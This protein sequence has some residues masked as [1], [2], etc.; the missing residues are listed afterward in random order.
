[1]EHFQEYQTLWNGENGKV[2][3]Y[4]SEIPYDGPST[5]AWSHNG[6]NGWAAYKVA[7][8]VKKHEAIGLGIYSFF[9]DAPVVMDN[10]AEA[11]KGTG[12]KFTNIMTFW[13]TGNEASAMNS[14][15]QEQVPDDGL[16]FD[17][18]SVT[19]MR[20]ADNADYQGVRLPA[21]I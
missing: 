1:M 16:R 7:D 13:L 21:V 14:I 2:Y 6:V 5:E 12:I 20:I 8:N 10:A 18:E 17:P 19:T 4:Q 3:F 15:C 11:P 9:R